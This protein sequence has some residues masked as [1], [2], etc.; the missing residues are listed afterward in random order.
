MPISVAHYPA[1]N[2]ASI[3]P[4]VL[5]PGWGFT[6]ECWQPLLNG[7]RETTDV[8]VLDI[9]Y[10]GETANQLCASIAE[11]LPQK[12][13]VMGWSLGGMLAT[14]FAAEYKDRIQGLITLA[15]NGVFVANAEWPLAMDT[16]TFE[17]FFSRVQKNP[18]QGLKKFLS[19]QTFGDVE[20][21]RKKQWLQ[22]LPTESNTNSLVQ[23]LQLL[24]YF[25]NTPYLSKINCPG[26]HFLGTKDALVPV[27]AFTLL[28]A[29]FGEQH[30]II[31]VEGA[32][33]VLHYPPAI[34]MDHLS[35][36]L[37]QQTY[38]VKSD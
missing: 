33:H 27:D 32:G 11:A 5:F 6:S 10:S 17:N 3:A 35:E 36:F 16:T 30:K 13:I 25:D 28:R 18:G 14:R 20:A 4:I 8:Y 23:G 37:S 24:A 12:I 21:E 19:L 22:Q 9:H 26:V 29:R 1:V 7:L 31:K 34:I 38:G 2:T 15:A